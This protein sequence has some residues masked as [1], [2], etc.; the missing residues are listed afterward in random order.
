MGRDPSDAR[1]RG[2]ESKSSIGG[3]P[4]AFINFFAYN[5]V[6]TGISCFLETII[7][8]TQ[9]EMRLS[10]ATELVSKG[11]IVSLNLLMWKEAKRYLFRCPFALRGKGREWH[12]KNQRKKIYLNVVCSLLILF[13]FNVV[14]F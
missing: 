12:K 1:S 7:K 14:L 10:S 5:V 9:K 2:S 4:F 6:H 13:F 11:E 3:G 8:P